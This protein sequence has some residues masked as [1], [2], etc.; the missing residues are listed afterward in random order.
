MRQASYTLRRALLPVLT[1]TNNKALSPNE[2]A[3][4]EWEGEGEAGKSS[5]KGNKIE[6]KIKKEGGGRE[7]HA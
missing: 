2:E 1:G 5:G 3:C 4:R 6:Q 7:T